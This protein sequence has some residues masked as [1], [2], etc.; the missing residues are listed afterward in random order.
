LTWNPFC[1]PISRFEF[2]YHCFCGSQTVNSELSHVVAE[3]EQKSQQSERVL[4]R[5]L[6]VEE[7]CG[8]KE[9][10]KVCKYTQ[11]IFPIL[12]I[13]THLF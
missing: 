10:E 1:L 8:V 5:L 7:M 4:A 9:R 2:K 3:R 13:Q 11:P 12:D 6:Y